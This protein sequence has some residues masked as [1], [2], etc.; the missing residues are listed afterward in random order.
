MALYDD[1]APTAVNNFVTLA[2]L[3]F[4]DGLPINQLNPSEL[5]VFGSPD[6]NPR[7]DAGYQIDA[8]RNLPV[9]LG[10]GAVAYVP[11]GG[12]PE[13]Q[14]SSSQLL[15]A[16]FPPPQEINADFSFFGRIVEGLDVLKQ[17]AV[18]DLVE[19]VTIETS[20]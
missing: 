7:S 12:G 4:F 18:G 16:L 2:N 8:E 3:G 10:E 17:L 14:S 9:E 15:V 5:L 1:L 11:L 19:S 20:E 13:A 6:N